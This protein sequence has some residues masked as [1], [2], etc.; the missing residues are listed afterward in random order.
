ML[1]PHWI[2][3]KKKCK[4]QLLLAFLIQIIIYLSKWSIVTDKKK[5]KDLWNDL[6]K[7]KKRIVGLKLLLN[8]YTP[9]YFPKKKSMSLNDNELNISLLLT[10]NSITTKTQNPNS[11]PKQ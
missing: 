1:N 10:A 7:K 11:K 5:K 6:M 4:T 9:T 3:K 2:W 8:I